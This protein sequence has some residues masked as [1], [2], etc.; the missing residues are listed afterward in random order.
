MIK[1][2]TIASF[3]DG[4]YKGRYDWQGGIPLTVGEII[5]VELKKRKLTYTLTNKTTKLIVDNGEQLVTVNY[6]FEL[7]K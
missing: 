7:L 3:K 6:Q 2:T 4:D 5:E 1:K